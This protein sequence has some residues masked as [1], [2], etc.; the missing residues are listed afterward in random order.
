MDARET[1]TIS[2]D[3]P[4][5]GGVTSPDGAVRYDA[6]DRVIELPKFEADRIL[7]SGHPGAASYRKSWSV[8]IDLKAMEAAKRAREGQQSVG[9]TS[10]D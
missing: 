4:N 7:K 5:C 3:D 2:V 10:D 9:K 6:N 8:G 1:V